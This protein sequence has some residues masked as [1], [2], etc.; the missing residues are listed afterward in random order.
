MVAVVAPVV[1]AVAVVPPRPPRP[2]PFWPVMPLVV[3]PVAPVVAVVAPVVRLA[4]PVGRPGRCAQ[5]GGV[6]EDRGR[7]VRDRE[8]AVLTDRLRED[9]E[10]EVDG[11][12]LEERVAEGDEPDLDRDLQVL[13]PA[14]LPEQV[15]DL[16]VDLGRVADDQADAEKERGDRADRLRLVEAAGVAAA[17]SGTHA[18]GPGGFVARGVVDSPGPRRDRGGDQLDQ[19][20]HVH[21]GPLARGRRRAAAADDRGGAVG[22]CDRLRLEVVRVGLGRGLRV[23]VRL[24]IGWVARGL[25]RRHDQVAD[26][27][28]LGERLAERGLRARDHEHLV[29]DLVGQ[30]QRAEHQLQR[31]LELDVAGR[32]GDGGGVGD[33]GVAQR[34]GIEDEV[35]P[36]VVGQE[37][38]RLLQR[39]LVH[40]DRDRL[41]ELGLDGERPG[42]LL[43]LERGIDPEPLAGQVLEVLGVRDAA[44]LGLGVGDRRGVGF[45]EG[46]D[47]GVLLLVADFQVTLV[48][49][50]H[51]G[52]EGE[53][54]GGDLVGVDLLGHRGVLL[55]RVVLAL[56]VGGGG[57]VHHLLHA[58]LLGLVG[59]EDPEPLLLDLGAVRLVLHLGLEG[60]LVLPGQLEGDLEATGHRAG[61]GLRDL[62]GLD[63]LEGVLV[64]GDGPGR[65]SLLEPAGLGDL[66]ADLGVE[67][68]RGQ[69]LGVRDRLGRV[70]GDGLARGAGSLGELHQEILDLLH[71]PLVEPFARRNLGQQVAGMLLIA[72]A[73]G[74]EG[75]LVKTQRGP[76]L[77]QGDLDQQV[78]GLS[79]HAQLLG[80]RLVGLL[81]GGWVVAVGVE[82]PGLGQ[83]ILAAIDRRRRG[84]RRGGA[85]GQRR[86]YVGLRRGRRGGV[87]LRLGQGDV[88]LRRGVGLRL[89]QGDVRL[90]RGVGLG[91]GR[92]HGVGLRRGRRSDVGLGAA[93][94]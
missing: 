12:V 71:Q 79:V 49:S 47:G 1:V 5:A 91:R 67:L 39:L 72:F 89:G 9:V 88:R 6:R 3:V 51:L 41:L 22:Q 92:R 55:G 8:R 85:D 26:V 20:G 35:Q 38:D 80:L 87:G 24:R 7:R 59:L 60:D 78:V 74:L 13:E 37:V 25:A 56:G 2:P 57:T 28:R 66:G 31:R 93:S 10:V 45:L 32:Q 15:G 17:E 33:L 84:H 44:E 68:L 43:G 63:G 83:Q 42:V 86:G 16:V 14:E 36:G 82:D 64:D 19:W 27:V 48:A 11:D 23:I 30:P 62:G 69:G 81:L 4:R 40:V 94:G 46:D 73:E 29:L 53:D 21:L 61:E 90:R 58:G 76:L 50:F 54:R 34:L 65:V 75:R 52:L 18:V 70:G 77:G